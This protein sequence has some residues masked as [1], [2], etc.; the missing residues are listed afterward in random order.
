MQDSAQSP[1]VAIVGAGAVGTT[2][3]RGLVGCGYRVAAILSRRTEAAQ[4]LADR[5]GAPV[6][7]S[8]G[9][10][11]PV[12]VR[13]VVVCVPDDDIPAVAE[14]LAALDHPWANTIVG[15][16]SGARTA[17]ALAPLA[18]EGA[19]TLSFHPLQTFTTETSPEAFQGIVVGL[20]G[21][22]RAV[23]AGKT[24]ARALGARPVRLTAEDKVRYHCTAALASNGLVALMGVV[25]EVFAAAKGEEKEK[26]SSTIEL[27]APLVEQTWS[28]LKQ[29][30]PEGVL[31]GPVARGD[32]ETVRTHLDALADATPH[33]VPLYVAL[34]TE[35]VR[36]AVRGGTLDRKQAEA[37][38]A[39]LRAA[40]G[41]SPDGENSPSPSF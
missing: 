31:T 2:L 35:M 12:E 37:V 41:G 21:N 6:A 34:S 18:R 5:V 30:S 23:A 24:L 3:A 25:E 22:D 33:L 1:P 28:N 15:H 32:E 39:A 29:S 14:A 38:L 20:E 11:L 7:A 26:F 13:L 17:A 40:A 27:V 16:T 36:I 10:A 4:A 8:S 19:A 9:D